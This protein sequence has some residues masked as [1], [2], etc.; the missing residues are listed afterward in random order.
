LLTKSRTR[1]IKRQ[2]KT[3]KR[4][5]F[6][7]GPGASHRSGE[8]NFPHPVIYLGLNRL[9]PLAAAKK[10]TFTGD[11]LSPKDKDWYVEQYSDILCLDEQDNSAKFMDTTEKRKFITPESSDY[12]GESCSAGQDNLS[13]ILTAILSLRRLKKELGRRYQGGMLLIDELDAT[14]HAFAQD[15]L[16]E[17]LS[18][19]SEELDLQVVA[20]SH[21]I[22]VL[23]KAYHSGLKRRI[24]VLYLVNLDDKITTQPFPTLQGILDHLKVDPTP[25][26]SKKPRR[27]SVVFE[28][29]E[30]ELLFKRICG[31][32][33]R[34]YVRCA[35]A[36]TLGAGQLKNLAEMSKSL[37]ELQE[38]IFVADGD[39]AK[40]WAKP[41]KNLL[42]L[43]GGK[44][45][46]TLIFLH[47]LAMKE[48]D[49]F[50]TRIYTRQFAITRQKG[51]KKKGENKKWVK[52]WYN[53]Q[54]QF[55]GRGKSKAFDSWVQAH[56][57]ECLEFCRRFLKLL[58]ARYKVEIPKEVIARTLAPLQ[59]P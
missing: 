28:D 54:A 44:R 40:T 26:A 51:D 27:V 19:V 21:S 55:W 59:G 15:K 37:P 38:M 49:P 20:T 4:M 2:R 50:W 41:P 35:N 14:L 1:T 47:L 16:L 29:K 8:G 30:G 39:M 58:K 3:K 17:L 53:G 11:A 6:V 33:L 10:C 9:W 34:N 23:E 32:K 52:A 25:P 24:K 45:P 31:S 57:P 46:E 42:A 7:T 36:D 5:R 12:D 18:D 13:Q 48:S 56:K 43:P 22:R